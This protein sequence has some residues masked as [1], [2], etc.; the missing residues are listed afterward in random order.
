VVDAM[1]EIYIAFFLYFR[2]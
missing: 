2:K 1:T